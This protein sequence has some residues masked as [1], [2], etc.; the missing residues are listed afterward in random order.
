MST[1]GLTAFDNT[2]NVTN[3]WLHEIMD[4]MGWTDRHR[5]YHAL[6]VVLHELR[7]RLS[8]DDVADLGAQLPMLVRGIFYEGWH[9]SGKPLRERKGGTFLAHIAEAYPGDPEVKPEEVARAVLH[10]L[11]KHVSGGEFRSIVHVVPSEVRN[12]FV[13]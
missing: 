6:R 4:R 2:T 11:A 1:T 5:A 10:T 7:D 13:A 8:V 9:P 3:K 12:L